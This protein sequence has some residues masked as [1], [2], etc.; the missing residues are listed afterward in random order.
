MRQETNLKRLMGKHGGAV[1]TAQIE[2]AGVSRVHIKKFVDDGLIVRA[3]RSMYA[4]PEL[5]EDDMARL[6]SKYPRGVFSLG[7]ALWLHRITDRIPW[8]YTLTF[9][10]G[11]H[12]MSLKNEA[13]LD[14]VFV[15][16]ELWGLGIVEVRNNFGEK[17]RTYDMERTICDVIHKRNSLGVELVSDAM[18]QFAAH[19]GKNLHN[20]MQYAELLRVAKP[21]RA[22]LEVLL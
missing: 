10:R 6:Q 9:P 18:K 5:V 3:R 20:L 14:R 19:Q 1:S 11:Y 13:I 21:L 17:V 15:K 7:T 8:R 4:L 12:A 2:A 22:Y 16:T